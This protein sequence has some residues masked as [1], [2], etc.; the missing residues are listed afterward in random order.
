MAS[1]C[2][3]QDKL[4]GGITITKT[5]GSSGFRLSRPRC[6]SITSGSRI[7]PVTKNWAPSSILRRNCHSRNRVGHAHLEIQ[8]ILLES[9][10]CST[11]S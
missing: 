6:R 8:E 5:G 11:I 4:K 3:T 2:S 1:I 9:L 7:G 10:R